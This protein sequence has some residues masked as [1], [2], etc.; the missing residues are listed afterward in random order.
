MT[1]SPSDRPQHGDPEP[2]PPIVKRQVCRCTCGGPDRRR[3]PATE[4]D[5]L[6]DATKRIKLGHWFLLDEAGRSEPPL[7][8]ASVLLDTPK[9]L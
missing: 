4:L 6:R 7:R 3:S 2:A 9:H 8:G 5:A 1:V